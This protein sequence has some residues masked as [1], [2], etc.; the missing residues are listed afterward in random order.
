MHQVRMMYARY[1]SQLGSKITMIHKNFN[2]LK[3]EK[4]LVLSS[5]QTRLWG[6][7][8]SGLK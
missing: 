3:K 4:I 2:K 6:T 7:A 8:I 5:I 1:T